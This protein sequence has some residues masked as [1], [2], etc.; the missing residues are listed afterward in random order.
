MIKSDLEHHC[1]GV[2]NGVHLGFALIFRGDGLDV[3]KLNDEGLQAG[4]L[5]VKHHFVEMLCGQRK[6]LVE[7]A[8][9]MTF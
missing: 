1:N 7:F 8:S 9:I 2:E 5:D 6:I 4:H 3:I